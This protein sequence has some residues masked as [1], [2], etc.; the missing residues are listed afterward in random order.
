MSDATQTSTF[1]DSTGRRWPLEIHPLAMKR[2]R[3][4]TGVAI[5]TL[6]DDS[7]AGLRSLFTDPVLLA[8]VL[9]VLVTDD[10]ARL[11]VTADDFGRALG[12]GVMEDAADAFVA[13]LADFSH[14]RVRAP[15]LALAGKEREFRA[16]AA[17]LATAKL[18]AIDVD[19]A[20]ATLL[21]SNGSA[22][23]SPASAGSPPPG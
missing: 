2:V 5:G 18:V 1:A 12:R 9:Y 11:G 16:K 23:G 13:A 10:A 14:R 19:E 4:R 15:L 21:T 20:L 7:F 17:D 22:G 8:D 3:E 6:L